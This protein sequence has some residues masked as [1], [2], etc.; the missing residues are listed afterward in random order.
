MHYMQL[1]ILLVI[2]WDLQELFFNTGKRSARAL[3]WDQNPVSP[4][5]QT[6]LHFCYKS[7]TFGCVVLSSVSVFT[8]TG[9]IVAM[10]R[11]YI[12]EYLG[13][14]GTLEY[15]NLLSLSHTHTRIHTG[16]RGHLTVEPTA[17]ALSFCLSRQQKHILSSYLSLCLQRRPSTGRKKERQRERRMKDRD[18][19][20]LRLG[21]IRGGWKHPSWQL[22]HDEI[23][24]ADMMKS[25]VLFRKHRKQPACVKRQL[26]EAEKPSD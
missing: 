6:F 17:I 4:I 2:A 15:S 5:Y 18:T 10:R 9:S 24:P 19:K 13:C 21:F 14:W 23:A 25:A 26:S 12:C 22:K 20:V 16:C 3:S 1:C 11:W 8:S 7:Q